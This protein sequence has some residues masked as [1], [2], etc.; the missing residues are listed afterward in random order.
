M[1][2]AVLGERYRGIFHG[3]ALASIQVGVGW[4]VLVSFIASYGEETG[5]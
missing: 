3:L 5:V 2:Y 1:T 4:K